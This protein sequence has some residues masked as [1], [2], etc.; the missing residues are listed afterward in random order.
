MSDQKMK[1]N[2]CLLLLILLVLALILPYPAAFAHSGRT[3]AYGGHRDN[4][5][6]SGLGPYHYHHGY[7][8]HLHTNGTCPYAAP[9]A[10]RGKSTNNNIPG[11]VWILLLIGGII[12]LR[13]LIAII[14]KTF[15][16]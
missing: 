10:S 7:G 1:K 12:I 8:P 6:A 4:N 2:V 9:Y 13:K 11:I 5:N 15:N 16:S 14:R 3:D